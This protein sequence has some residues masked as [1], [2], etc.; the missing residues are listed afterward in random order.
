MVWLPDASPRPATLKMV[1]P[2]AATTVPSTDQSTSITAG[3]MTLTC[4]VAAPAASPAG[5]TVESIGTQLRQT[6]ITIFSR[7]T[8]LKL[9]F[10][11]LPNRLF[12]I[13]LIDGR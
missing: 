10:G 8:E 4:S 3:S 12:I 9:V 11:L 1:P 2:F 13:E 6:S 7:D 5:G